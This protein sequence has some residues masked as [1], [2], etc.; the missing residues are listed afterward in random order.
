M[1]RIKL[2]VMLSIVLLLL[3]ATSCD[4]KGKEAPTPND[5]LEHALLVGV[6]VVNEQGNNGRAY[7]QM[8]DPEQTK[9]IDNKNGVPYGF[10]TVPTMFGREVYVMPDFN[11]TGV[12]EVNRYTIKD[13]GSLQHFASRLPFPTGS[14]GAS[15]VIASKDKGYISLMGH[16]KVLIFNPTTL[17]KIGEIDLNTYAHSDNVKV[18][19]GAMVIRD[20]KLYIGLGQYNA[21]FMPTKHSVEL[22]VIDIKSDKVLKKIVSEDTKLSAATR[23]IEPNSIFVD[24]KGD[25]Y[26]VCMGSFGFIPDYPSG[27]LRIK[28]GADTFDP[29]WSISLADTDIKGVPAKGNYFASSVYYGHGKLYSYI[30]V[31]ALAPNGEN[32]YLDRTLIATEIDLSAKTITRING[33]LPTN[34]HAIAICTY[35]NKIAWGSNNKKESGVYLYDPVTKKVDGPILTVQG[36]VTALKEIW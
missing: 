28:K 3:T 19:P 35:Q 24:E 29:N 32:P 5:K 6:T 8:I 7:A 18:S 12:S 30:S 10:G 16:G 14:N 31:A 21:Q 15:M 4:N 34:P 22:A 33:I 13:D 11:S 17:Q 23:P 26:V 20:G 36:S 2:N 1:E 25:I 9:S 27:I